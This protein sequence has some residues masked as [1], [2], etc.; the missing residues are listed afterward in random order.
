MRTDLRLFHSLG[1]L[2]PLIIALFHLFT[3]DNA[4][5]DN[6]A[7]RVRLGVPE[8]AYILAHRYAFPYL[9]FLPLLRIDSW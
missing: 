1:F 9:P 4:F 7:K 6:L 3:L 8:N 5:R 2:P